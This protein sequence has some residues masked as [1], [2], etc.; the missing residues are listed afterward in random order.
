MV[1]HQITAAAAVP[2]NLPLVVVLPVEILYQFI[3][4]VIKIR[5]LNHIPELVCHLSIKAEVIEFHIAG[6]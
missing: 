6:V 5:H 3:E 2:G 4:L 1:Q